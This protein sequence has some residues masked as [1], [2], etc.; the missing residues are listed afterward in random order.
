MSIISNIL[1]AL[2]APQTTFSMDG[3][4][5]GAEKNNDFTGSTKNDKLFFDATVNVGETFGKG[6]DYSTL[7][8]GTGIDTLEIKLTEKQY[9][10]FKAEACSKIK[11]LK[12]DGISAE[13]FC[14]LVQIATGQKAV[15]FNSIGVELKG[16][17]ILKFNVVKEAPAAPAASKPEKPGEGDEPHNNAAKDDVVGLNGKTTFTIKDLLNNDPGSA[18]SLYFG[19]SINQDQSPAGQA[20][21]LAAHGITKISNTDGGTYEIAIGAT[22]ISYYVKMGNNGTWSQAHVT[23]HA[24]HAPVAVGEGV[25]V[26][27][28]AS[29]TVPVKGVLAND[30]DSDAGQT[31]TLTV[32]SAGTT[33]A[34]TVVTASGTTIVG[35][36]GD[37][38][39][40]SDGSYTY[41]ANKAAA[42]D[43][44]DHKTDEFSYTVVD[45]NGGVSNVA[46]LTITVNG[47]NDAPT[48]TGLVDGAEGTVKEDEVFTTGGKLN[49]ADVDH[50]EAFFKPQTNYQGDYGKFKIEADG[51]WSYVLDN[52]H[53]DVQKLNNGQSLT[54]TFKVYSIDNT[55]S[56]ITV[57]INGA[58]EA[59]VVV[60][61]DPKGA[62]L[63][64][65]NFDHY[66]MVE[67]HGSFGIVNLT[68]GSAEQPDGQIHYWGAKTTDGSD[69]HGNGGWVA[70]SGEIVKGNA[71]EGSIAATSTPSGNDFWLDTQNSPGGIDIYNSFVDTTGGRFLLTFDIGTHDF[72]TGNMEETN[73]NAVFEVQIDGVAV[74]TLTAAQVNAL[75]GGNDKMAHIEVVV[76]GF[77][78]DYAT[79]HQ[80]RLVDKTPSTD[81]YVGFAIDSINI[82]DWDDTKCGTDGELK[83]EWTFENHT[84]EGGDNIGGAP[85]GFWSLAQY[86]ADNNLAVGQDPGTQFSNDIQVHGVNGHRGL[87]TAASPGNIFL[88]AIPVGRGGILGQ[89]ATMPDLEAG[90]KYHATVSI[91]K[92]DHSANPDL[93][94][95]GFD[96]TDQDAWVQFQFNDKVLT[97]KASDLK[98][99]P[100]NNFVEYDVVFEG[101]EGEDGFS[102]MSHGTHDD[103]QGL[104]IDTIQIHDWVI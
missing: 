25:S 62:L 11:D 18:N 82:Y 20:A 12:A 66:Q 86:V 71:F 97:V 60:P 100:A 1:E 32:K 10:A 49:I 44:D 19:D 17:E 52:D 78:P 35:T 95:Q 23:V 84:Q 38:I 81:G 15:T 31:Q 30:T 27:E 37:L 51:T 16:W 6:A 5:T 65:E 45:S 94:A 47:V 14:S 24:N 9:A 63:F 90:K 76:D 57:K 36:Y 75:A 41:V 34:N 39:I 89:G 91:L 54:D 103:P 3:D 73:P 40:K 96:G 46:K 33:A 87:D 28:D 26:N 4:I 50:L 53:V 102:I 80:I 22:D 56:V 77:N 88:Q 83:A 21:Y 101:V 55:E 69:P 98:L 92:Q 61:C 72:G 64:Q 7:D 68:A 70:A 42:L 2:T 99:N 29:I 48:I 58:D 8:G 59:P 85:L 93:V 13:E 104:I 43:G 79:S 74:K 67:D